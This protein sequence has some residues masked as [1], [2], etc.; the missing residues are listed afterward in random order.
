MSEA[1]PDDDYDHE[2]MQEYLKLRERLASLE[3]RVQETHLKLIGLTDERDTI[4]RAV[5]EAAKRI[6]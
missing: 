2:A 4:L 6:N 3:Y 5:H 1:Q